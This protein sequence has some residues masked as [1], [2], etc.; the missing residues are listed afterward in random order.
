[1]YE[2]LSDLLTCQVSWPRGMVKFRIYIL[3]VLSHTP[4]PG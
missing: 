1:M 4:H 3:L 2:K